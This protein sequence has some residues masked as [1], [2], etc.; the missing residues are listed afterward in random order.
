MG[1]LYSQC[2]SDAHDKDA[3]KIL[4][5]VRSIVYK[6]DELST[7]CSLYRPDVVCITETWLN[8]DVLNTEVGI[9]NY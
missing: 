5:Y 8:E 2:T 9:P 7:N 1:S 6:I 4:Y 3:L